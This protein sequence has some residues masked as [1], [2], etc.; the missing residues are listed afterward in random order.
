MA[1]LTRREWDLLRLAVL[2]TRLPLREA[3]ESIYRELNTRVGLV[4]AGEWE[5]LLTRLTTII[6]AE[7][8]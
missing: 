7:A 3:D 6:E 4:T 8:R 5:A 1:E 2:G